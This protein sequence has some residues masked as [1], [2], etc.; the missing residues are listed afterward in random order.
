MK[1]LLLIFIVSF[2]LLAACEKTVK[3][4]IPQKEP[5][6]VINGRLVKNDLFSISVGKSRGVLTPGNNQGSLQEQYTVKTAVPVVYENGVAI[7]TLIYQPADYS[8]TTIRNKKV[9]DGFAY[10]ILVKAPGFN[11]A[12]ASSLLPSQSVIAELRRI[13]NSRTSASGEQQDEITIRL[14]D[15]A[16]E[17]NFYLIQVANTYSFA[18]GGNVVEK[19]YVYCVSTSDKDIELIGDNADPLSTDNCY[20]GS[21]LL[22]RDNNFN[23][24]QKLVKLFVAS[25]E[26]ID[27]TDPA[28]H[29]IYRP[30]V[31]V[32][33]ITEDEFKFIKSFNA[34]EN[35]GDNPF[36]EPVNV[37]SNVKNGYGI[38]A[39]STMAADT[40]R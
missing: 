20:D 33:R 2:F 39:L 27:Y 38:F 18:G 7:D 8:Y 36:A 24:A 34:Y 13:R 32:S 3:I 28:T 35:A 25:S 21:K 19:R 23:G 37:Y 29:R 14:N 16:A 30:V 10:T 5:R 11:T 22:M 31:L 9:R 6:L 26:L 4:D 40:L 15:P 1:P 17:K 12:E